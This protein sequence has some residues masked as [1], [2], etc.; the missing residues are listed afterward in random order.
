VSWHRPRPFAAPVGVHHPIPTDRTFTRP[1]P[2]VKDP[3]DPPPVV[4]VPVLAPPPQPEPAADPAPVVTE[5][6]F[7]R[8][9][10]E[11]LEWG[12][13]NLPL[14]REGVAD[15][16]VLHQ[17]AIRAPRITNGGKLP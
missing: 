17:L 15:K 5:T 16:F 7:H 11:D 6:V 8:G 1:H 3:Q 14:F 12:Y 13:R 4:V 2:T 9:I 10:R